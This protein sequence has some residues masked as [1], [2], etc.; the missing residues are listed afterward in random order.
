MRHG[1]GQG[2]FKADGRVKI[3]LADSA[4]AHI[5]LYSP[6]N[7]SPSLCA[8]P[9]D[10]PKI[11]AVT[12]FENRELTSR[13]LGAPRGGCGI[14]GVWTETE[15]I[16]LLSVYPLSLLDPNRHFFVLKA[17]FDGSG[18]SHNKNETILTLAGLVSSDA[19]WP[20]FEREWRQMLGWY[21]LKAFHATD[22]MSDS[23]AF[24]GWGEEKVKTLVR[25][26]LTIISKFYG[27]KVYFKSCTIKLADYRRAKQEIPNLYKAE[28]MCVDFCVGTGLPPDDSD[29]GKEFSDV[30]LYF[31]MNED[32]LKTIYPIWSKMRKRKREF[33]WAHQVKVI[34]PVP[35]EEIPGIQAADL[36]AWIVAGHYRKN[37]KAENFYPY[38]KDILIGM[39]RVYDY[40]AILRDYGD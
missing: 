13:G 16:S 40:K 6:S 39:H 11:Q 17:Y 14:G 24:R 34:L 12:H 27:R 22:A 2:Q 4:P 7:S 33:T 18:K 8:V 38:T 37:E 15:G 35:S 23:R 10:R 29:P 36:L 32:F 19:A 28:V 9:S 31:D 21:G 26:L 5:G 30:S 3:L 25:Q 1:A 20:D